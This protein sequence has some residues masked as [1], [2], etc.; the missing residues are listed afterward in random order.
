MQGI[1]IKVKIGLKPNGH[2]DY[3]DW[4][5]LPL[6]GA[7][8]KSEREERVAAQQIIKWRYDKQSGHDDDGVD[9]PRGIQWGMM[10]V[11]QQFVTEATAAWPDRVFVMTEAEAEDFWDNRV[12]RSVPDV[13]HD[14]DVL[15]GLAA[16]RQLK[17]ALGQSLTEIDTR[18]AKALDPADPEL[19]TRHRRETKWANVKVDKNLDIKK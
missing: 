5:T 15:Q 1:P 10:V 18:I 8:E 4:T 2:A 11:S 9:S 7:G 12:Y 17:E 6:A 16:E 14:T 3:P 19:G 13:V